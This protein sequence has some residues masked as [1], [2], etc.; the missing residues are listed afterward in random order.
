MNSAMSDEEF[1]RIMSLYDRYKAKLKLLYKEDPFTYDIDKEGKRI[2]II[3]YESDGSEIVRIPNFVTDSELGVF[4][5]LQSQIIKEIVLGEN[6]VSAIRL[7]SGFKQKHIK[8][9]GGSQKLKY[10]PYMLLRQQIESIEIDLQ[11]DVHIKKLTGF[12]QRSKYLKEIV[13]KNIDTSECEDFQYMFNE[14]DRLKNI[15]LSKLQFKQAVTFEGMFEQQGIENVVLDLT[16]INKDTP[17]NLSNIANKCLNLKNFKFIGNA[18]VQRISGMFSGCTN[19]EYV[20]IQNLNFDSVQNVVGTFSNCVKLKK[21]DGSINLKNVKDISRFLYNC[22]QLTDIDIQHIGLKNTNQLAGL[23]SFC[24]QLEQIDLQGIDF[25][26]G[27]KQGEKL[28]EGCSSLKNLNLGNAKFKDSIAMMFKGCG[29]EGTIDLTNRID[30]G[31]Y[32]SQCSLSLSPFAFDGA[33]QDS[34]ISEIV[35]GPEC[36]I[37]TYNPFGNNQVSQQHCMKVTV[38]GM[39][40]NCKNLKKII[41]KGRLLAAI[42]KDEQADQMF[43]QLPK[44]EEIDFLGGLNLCVVNETTGITFKRSLIKYAPKLKVIKSLQEIK[45]PNNL[46]N[47]FKKTNSQYVDSDN[48]WIYEF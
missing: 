39:F 1:N 12:A 14:C 38:Y 31:E 16:E 10:M 48:L 43:V 18:N 22:N 33:F 11:S 5:S 41:F 3:K 6:M 36:N 24:S 7:L 17:L 44:L 15:D 26:T 45:Y 29:Y 23:F 32:N 28:F 27:Q 13:F 46:V 30:F 34:M 8:I 21:I 19:L 25:S 37:Y 35:I 2:V 9:S 4:Q 40:V 42:G 20:D 47:N